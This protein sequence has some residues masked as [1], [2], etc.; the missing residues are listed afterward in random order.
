MAGASAA[1]GLRRRHRRGA[2]CASRPSGLGRTLGADEPK[3]RD[4]AVE[5]AVEKL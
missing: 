5:C 4:A 3:W 2:L 1:A